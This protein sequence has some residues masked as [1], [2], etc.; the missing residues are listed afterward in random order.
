[1]ERISYEVDPFNRLV[2]SASGEKGGLEEFRQVLD[3]QFKVDEDNNLSYHVKTPL[4]EDENIP[5][6]VMI[7]GGWSLTDNHELRL[8]LDEE[9]RETFGDQLTLQGQILDVGRSSLIFSMTTRT[10]AGGQTTYILNL[11]GF[12]RADENNRLSFYVR[13]QTDRPDILTFSSAWEINRN[14]Q[15]VYRYAKADLIRKKR[16]IHELLFKGHWDIKKKLRISYLVDG[17]SDS[18]FDFKAGAGI[19]A[20]DYVKYELDIGAAQGAVGSNGVTKASADRP[21]ARC[22][23]AQGPSVGVHRP[24]RPRREASPRAQP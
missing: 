4:A 23:G 8:T 12:W 16:E 1:M 19:L 6:Q 3:G 2:V 15:I 9:S 17:S 11:Q 24:R 22:G 7:S 18:E 20:W 21:Q 13:R 14:H 10:D 5:H